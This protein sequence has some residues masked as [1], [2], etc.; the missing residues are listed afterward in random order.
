MERGAVTKSQKG[1]KAHVERKVGSVFSGSH[2]DKVRK[3]TH[4]FSVMT[5]KHK[6]TCTVVRDKKW[7]IVF[8]RTN[9]EDQD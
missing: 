9:F 3:E 5:K 8:S 4:V 7:T 1:K 6:E 2:M